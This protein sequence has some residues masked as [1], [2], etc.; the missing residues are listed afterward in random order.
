MGDTA[1]VYAGTEPGRVH[2]GL[3]E[4]ARSA[5]CLPERLLGLDET[6]RRTFKRRRPRMI[7]TFRQQAECPSSVSILCDVQ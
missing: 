2:L 3:L 7:T 4:A 6:A 5:Q 1:G